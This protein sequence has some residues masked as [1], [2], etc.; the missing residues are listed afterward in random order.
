MHEK[1][2]RGSREEFDLASFKC[3]P[4]QRF[5]GLFMSFLNTFCIGMGG[6][7]KE[8]R[9]GGGRVIHGPRAPDVVSLRIKGF[10]EGFVWGKDEDLF[11]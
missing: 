10:G 3:F 8:P 11:L 7:R 2:G 9:K 1:D 6:F 5:V 4:R